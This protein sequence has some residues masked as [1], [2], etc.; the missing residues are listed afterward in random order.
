MRYNR[1]YKHECGEGNRDGTRT[2]T[3]M[4]NGNVEMPCLNDATVGAHACWCG[5]DVC[6]SAHVEMEENMTVTCG[7][8]FC[9]ISCAAAA[10]IMPWHAHDHAT[11][12]TVRVRVPSA[13]VCVLCCCCSAPKQ[14]FGCAPS[15]MSYMCTRLDYWLFLCRRMCMC[16]CMWYVLHWHC[17]WLQLLCLLLHMSCECCKQ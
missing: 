2:S 17:C 6:V 13:C 16:M 5:C 9:S 10:S 4:R 1:I 7:V 3:C 11:S 12:S 14:A 15:R 8:C